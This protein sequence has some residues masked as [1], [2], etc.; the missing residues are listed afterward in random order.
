MWSSWRHR[1]PY[2]L[3]DRNFFLRTWFLWRSGKQVLGLSGQTV[4]RRSV[5]CFQKCFCVFHL[6]LTNEHCIS[7]SI[8][9]DKPFQG[10]MLLLNVRVA[11]RG[12]HP[13]PRSTT[14]GS[15]L[16]L[17]MPGTITAGSEVRP[18]NGIKTAFV[19]HD[20]PPL[21]KTLDSVPHQEFKNCLPGVSQE[22]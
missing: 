10:L 17:L 7:I 20:K 15:R 5:C 12:L 16:T 18:R 22:F 6:R 4:R 19:N 21:R 8:N 2:Q 9:H 11:T 13:P 3:L 14:A 1:V